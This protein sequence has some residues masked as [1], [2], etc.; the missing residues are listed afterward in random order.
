MS[1]RSPASEAAPR[2]AEAEAAT[3]IATNKPAKPKK[4]KHTAD[5]VV[6]IPEP[7][8]AAGN[9]V[10]AKQ[11]E[12]RKQRAVGASA[13]PENRES[14]KSSKAKKMDMKRRRVS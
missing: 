12:E 1:L 10:K 3:A 4:R 9:R 6:G 14:Q 2:Q 7:D 13:I 5:G 8:I 11:A